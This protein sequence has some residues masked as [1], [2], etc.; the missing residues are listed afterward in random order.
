[1]K[2]HDKRE[3][4]ADHDEGVDVEANRVSRI[5]DNLA[6]W[7]ADARRNLPWRVDRDA[8]RVWISEVML[9]QTTVAAV[10]P[11]F[12]R[13]IERFPTVQALAAAD[14]G[15]VLKA[16]E[17]LGYYRRAR[18]LH[19]AARLVASRH[20][21]EFPREAAV[22]RELP[23]VGRYIA[24]AVA[25]IAFDRPE[26]IL[27]ANTQRVLARWLAWRGPLSASESQSRLWRAAERFVPDRGAGEFNQAFMELGAL[28]CLPRAPRC[29]ACPVREDCRARELGLQDVLPVSTPRPK[30]LEVAEECALTVRSGRILVVRRGE[31]GLWRDMWEFPTRHVEG[32]DPA[33]RAAGNGADL[34]E[35][36]RLLTGVAVQVGPT[37]KSLRYAVTK[38]VVQLD[39]RAAVGLSEPTRVAEGF[40]AAIWATLDDLEGLTL[41]APSRKLAGWV[42]TRGLDVL[43]KSVQA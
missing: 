9:V 42:A 2:R 27:E 33:G 36:V 41:T 3:K 32:V 1:M 40:I 38:H 7:Y 5:R 23:G 10:V 30:P 20:G 11:Y 35:S 29:L 17:G 43:A 21:G 13:F 18:Q 39:A 28:V 37:A 19:A 15:E 22:L 31:V 6:A 8:Y 24:G 14:E 12:E 26:A 16:W 25:S 34:A 4:K